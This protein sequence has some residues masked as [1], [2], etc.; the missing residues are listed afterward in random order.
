M[1]SLTIYLFVNLLTCFIGLAE[2]AEVRSVFL[3]VLLDLIVR[4]TE[5][6]RVN[7]F[8]AGAFTLEHSE[9]RAVLI[10]VER[11]STDTVH[12][13]ELARRF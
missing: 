6:I 9:S 8:A 2:G 7:P 5:A 3:F 10:R 12:R 13:L 11:P 4:V 1:N